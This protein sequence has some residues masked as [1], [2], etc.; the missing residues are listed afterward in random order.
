VPAFSRGV[1]PAA[2]FFS[3]ENKFD[4]SACH[5]SRGQRAR[6]AVGPMGSL[7]QEMQILKYKAVTGGQ[8]GLS[9]DL[10]RGPLG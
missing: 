4:L 6:S 5:T 9:S 1:A 3:L 2:V 8:L 7:I 10:G